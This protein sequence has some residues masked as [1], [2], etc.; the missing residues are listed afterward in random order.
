LFERVADT[1]PDREA[2]VCGERRLT[3]RELDERAT[4]LANGLAGLGVGTGDHVGLLAYDTTEHVEAMLACFKLRAVPVNVNWRYAGAELSYLFDDASLAALVFDPALRPDVETPKITLEIGD[5]YE[6]L[7]ASSAPERQLLES[8]CGVRS[9]DDR[10]VLYTGGTTGLPKGVVWRQEDIFFAV[11][12]GGNPGGPAIEHPDDIGRTVVERPGLRLQPFLPPGDPG[13]AQFVQLAL[14]PIMHAGGQWS[15]LGTL[16]GGGKVVLH[17]HQHLDLSRVMDLVEREKVISLNLV[18]D[19]HAIPLLGVLR[20]SPGRW[21]TSSLRLLGSGGSM[22]SG[23]AKEGLLAAFPSVLAISEA[24]GSSEAPVEAISLTTRAAGPPPSLHFTA[25]PESAVLDD[26]LRP[27]VPG[28][29]VVGRLATRGRVPIEYY[30]DPVKSAATFVDIGGERWSVTGDM[31]VVEGDG[32]IR[33]L[34]RGSMCINTGGEKVY[35]EEVESVLKTH[36]DVADVLVVGRPDERFGEQVVVLVETRDG[37]PS[38]SLDALQAHCRGRLAGYKLPRALYAVE[39]IERTA[40][41][42]PDY[43]WARSV[44]PG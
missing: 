30:K 23:H 39:H 32:T 21:E 20:A 43:G 19:A 18:G 12:G 27:V 13:P 40:S 1:V 29:G 36:P 44:L 37:S 8:R 31:A 6:A 33:L 41:G 26:A 28:S 42:K 35:P 16:L 5:G 11:L 15:A 38:P 7:V 14:G 17:A 10:Y 2:V 25:R 34:G 24:V 9:P 4:R 22:L 3:Y